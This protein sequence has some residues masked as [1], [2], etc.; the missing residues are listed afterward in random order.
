MRGCEEEAR[1]SAVVLFMSDS[2]TAVELH[3]GG[4]LQDDRLATPQRDMHSL[5]YWSRHNQ[6]AVTH[7]VSKYI[8]QSLSNV[9]TKA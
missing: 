5:R 6:L 1:L 8:V 2:P 7:K 4:E 3:H 9:L